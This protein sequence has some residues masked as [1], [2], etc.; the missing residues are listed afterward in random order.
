MPP[1]TPISEEPVLWF[2][3]RALGSVHT[4]MMKRPPSTP[5]LAHP[6]AEKS[7]QSQYVLSVH[8]DKEGVPVNDRHP[9]LWL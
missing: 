3:H 7:P 2:A 9:R 1:P 6:Q 5:T 4:T 8:P